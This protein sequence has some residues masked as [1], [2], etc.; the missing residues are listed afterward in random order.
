MNFIFIVG[1]SAIVD[2]GVK[3]KLYFK[4]GLGD[5]SRTVSRR[6]GTIQT[7]VNYSFS[8]INEIIEVNL[9]IKVWILMPC[10]IA[11]IEFQNER[12]K[13]RIERLCNI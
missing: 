8:K 1:T 6:S 4:N 3:K 7:R 10:S 13:K 12:S 5:V 2:T 11:K 9:N